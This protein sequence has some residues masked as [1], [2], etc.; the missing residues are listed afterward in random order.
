MEGMDIDPLELAQFVSS[1]LCHDLA[2]P[3]GVIGTMIEMV[4][5]DDGGSIYSRGSELNLQNVL[6]RRG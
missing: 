6:V 5:D 3:V 4:S 1:R 2:G